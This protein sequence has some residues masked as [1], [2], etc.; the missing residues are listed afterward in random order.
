[1]A[2]ILKVD[3][4]RGNASAGDITITSEGGSAT[5]QLQQG[6]A[7]CWSRFTPSTNTELDSINQSSRSDDGSGLSTLNF[8]NNFNN[9]NHVGINNCAADSTPTTGDGANVGTVYG[10]TTALTK[11]AYGYSGSGGGTTWYLFDYP[12]Q[13]VVIHGDLA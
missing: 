4:L 12:N 9:A 1:M 7:K 10:Q 6:V 3:D 5:M 8:S 11:L 2:S 13:K